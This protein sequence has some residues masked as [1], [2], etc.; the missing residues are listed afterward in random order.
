MM[1]QVVKLTLWMFLVA[2]PAFAQGVG[3]SSSLPP[4]P[5]V[6]QTRGGGEVV[7]RVGGLEVA[8]VGTNAAVNSHAAEAKVER[9]VPAFYLFQTQHRSTIPVAQFVDAEGRAK[10]AT[11]AAEADEYRRLGLSESEQAVFI[12]AGPVEG[13]SELFHLQ[14]PGTGSDL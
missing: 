12:Y 3:E 1:R 8:A 2:V 5:V 11:D 9:G 7:F 4:V 6:R 13:S 10:L 14:D